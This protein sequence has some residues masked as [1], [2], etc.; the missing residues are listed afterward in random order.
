M[1]ARALGWEGDPRRR[2]GSDGSTHRAIRVLLAGDNEALLRKVSDGLGADPE[3][4]VV[5]IVARSDDVGRALEQLRPDV[6]VV[7]VASLLAGEA[8]TV[9]L[10]AWIGDRTRISFSGVARTAYARHCAP[11][12]AATS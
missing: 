7:D 6:L 12:R 5:G 10:C 1:P 2:A 3:I 11:G 8:D 9:A 4:G